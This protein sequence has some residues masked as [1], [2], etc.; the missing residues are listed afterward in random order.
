MKN[1]SP[2]DKNG[3]RVVILALFEAEY[4][5]LHVVSVNHQQCQLI[6][7]TL[8][9]A[10]FCS[11]VLPDMSLRFITLNFPIHVFD[12]LLYVVVST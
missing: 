10:R 4:Q 6:K 1:L 2:V 8:L 3:L 12:Q 9:L 5:G 11:C 7:C